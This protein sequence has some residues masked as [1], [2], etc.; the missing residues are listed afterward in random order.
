VKVEG[1]FPCAEENKF[2]LLR[3]EPE[4]IFHE[5]KCTRLNLSQGTFKDLTKVVP[6]S[7]SLPGRVPHFTGRQLVMQELVEKILN[8]KLVCV[9]GI[10]GVGKSAVLKEVAIYISER[11]VF[12]DGVLFMQLGDC[13][14]LDALASVMYLKI[15]PNAAPVQS[16]S[17][18]KQLIITQLV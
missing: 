2:I 10:L 7:D 11:L 6:H 5:H 16:K 17:E 8:N 4:S 18:I 12:K 14:S 15:L 3:T 13:D 1:R 9:K